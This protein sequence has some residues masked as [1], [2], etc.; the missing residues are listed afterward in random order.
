M[1]LYLETFA[2]ADLLREVQTLATPLVEKNGNTL[3]IDTPADLGSMH[4]DLTKL[5]QS[6]LNLLSNA[7][8]FTEQG[9]VTLEATRQHDDGK[10]TVRFIVVDT[11]IGMTEEQLGRLFQAFSQADVATAT[12]TLRISSALTLS[13]VS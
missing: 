3:L 7:A 9:T 5:K 1:D 8:K 13:T 11:G 2:V 6:L 12:P 4:T 10:E